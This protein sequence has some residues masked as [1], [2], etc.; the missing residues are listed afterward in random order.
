MLQTLRTDTHAKAHSQVT[1]PSHLGPSH[2]IPLLG[3]L[4]KSFRTS[5]AEDAASSAAPSSAHGLVDVKL[6]LARA[7]DLTDARLEKLEVK[8]CTGPING[9]KRSR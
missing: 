1:L 4:V 3:E 2:A 5:V 6:D 7:S 8:G 9:G